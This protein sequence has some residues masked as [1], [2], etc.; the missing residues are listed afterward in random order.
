M[1]ERY[2]LARDPF[3]E[4]AYLFR[5]WIT[6][7]TFGVRVSDSKVLCKGPHQRHSL[8]IAI[9]LESEVG[10]INAPAAE[11]EEITEAQFESYAEIIDLPVIPIEYVG[12]TATLTIGP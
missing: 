12:P 11:C 2:F 6:D 7:P 8:R 10:K 3:G 4:A 9:Q 5:A 1:M